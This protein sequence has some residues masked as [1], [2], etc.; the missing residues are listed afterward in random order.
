MI[1]NFWFRNR[2]LVLFTSFC[3]SLQANFESLR[4][5]RQGKHKN[6]FD[7]FKAITR[8]IT[9][10]VFAT[11]PLYIISVGYYNKIKILS[12]KVP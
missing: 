5:I 9:L 7:K 3:L 6:C 1:L 4:P 2:I 8:N 12:S 11:F 10:Q